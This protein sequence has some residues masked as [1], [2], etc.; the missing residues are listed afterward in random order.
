MDNII[1]LEGNATPQ[2]TNRDL[3]TLPF[4]ARFN[5]RPHSYKDMKSGNVVT[6]PT[7]FLHAGAVSSD[8]AEDFK[9]EFNE[10]LKKY[11][12]QFAAN[13]P[14]STLIPQITSD[15]EDQSWRHGGNNEN[16]FRKISSL[17]KV[18]ETLLAARKERSEA[19]QNQTSGKASNEVEM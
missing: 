14:N 2:A 18:K 12:V 3:Q 8:K 11:D 1:S 10:L 19:E 16:L 6:V 9:K 5:V 13:N 15:K 7:V 4:I 17:P